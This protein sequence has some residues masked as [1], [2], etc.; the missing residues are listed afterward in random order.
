MVGRVFVLFLVVGHWFGCVWFGLV[1]LCL[2]KFGLVWFGF[3][4]V[5]FAP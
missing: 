4:L 1:R 5:W 2:A 3:G